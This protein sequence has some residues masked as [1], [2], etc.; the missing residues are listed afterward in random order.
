[1][2]EQG[3]ILNGAEYYAILGCYSA[4]SGNFLG[5]FRDNLPVPS[6]GFSYFAA[7]A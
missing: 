4:S 5:T 7:E 3:K 1:M 6:S 2:N